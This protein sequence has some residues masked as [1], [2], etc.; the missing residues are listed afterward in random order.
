VAIATNSSPPPFT[1]RPSGAN[2]AP[3]LIEVLASNASRRVGDARAVKVFIVLSVAIAAGL[4]ASARIDGVGPLARPE[5]SIVSTLPLPVYPLAIAAVATL[6]VSARAWWFGLAI[7]FAWLPF[8]DLVRKL[9]GNDLRVYFV[10]DL[11]LGASLVAIAPRLRGCWRRP[12]GELWLPTMGLILLAI[13][14]SLPTALA[15]P[16]VPLIGL[17]QRFLFVALLPVGVYIAQDSERLRKA[18]LLLAV[19]GAAACVVGI[20]QVLIGPEFLNPQVADPFLQHLTVVKA[21]GSEFVT[22]PSGTFTDV[23][24]FASMTIIAVVLGLMAYRLSITTRSRRTASACVAVSFAGAFASGS[25]TSFLVALVI[26]AYAL[27]SKRALRR[28]V[29]RASRVLLIVAVLA[30]LIDGSVRETSTVTAD[31]YETTL[32]PSSTGFEAGSRVRNYV[33]DAFTGVRIGG[34]VGRGTGDQSTGRRYVDAAGADFKF[35]TESGWGS[36]AIEWGTFGLALWIAWSTLWIRKAVR[37]ARV[38]DSSPAEPIR[39][40]IALYVGALLTVLFALGS[41]F[42]DNYI[43]NVYFWLLSG[44]AFAMPIPISDDRLPSESVKYR[45]SVAAPVPPAASAAPL[46]PLHP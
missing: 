4:F 34:L 2:A 8:E 5:L 31:F 10:K 29:G 35:A 7:F 26:V 30:V 24:R 23:S 6:L 36:I 43:A 45:R 21:A 33:L 14:Y 46:Q 15:S 44:I 25:R 19:L 39:G 27:F 32:N 1:E 38:H 13:V 41:G 3:T 16:S 11:L 40:L 28:G 12:L 22:R 18:V 9:T 17:H 42:F 37:R 20:L